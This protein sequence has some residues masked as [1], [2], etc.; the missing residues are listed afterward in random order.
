MKAR[1]SGVIGA[2]YPILLTMY[3]S[4]STVPSKFAFPF[5]ASVPGTLPPTAASPSQPVFAAGAL[6]K[7]A[8]G[9]RNDTTQLRP[10]ERQN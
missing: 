3:S 10:G 6:K 1:Y 9:E 7:N 2:R 4:A 5:T 8:A